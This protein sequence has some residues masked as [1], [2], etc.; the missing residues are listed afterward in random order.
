MDR[1]II[2][3]PQKALKINLDKSIY[4]TFS[5]IGAGQEVVRHFFRAGAASGTVAKAMSAYDKEFSDAI[6][7]REEDGRYVTEVRLR[8]MLSQEYRLMTERIS[9][10]A[11]PNACFFSFANTVATIDF[12][13]RYKGHGWMG[14][15]FQLAPDRD[16]NEVIIHVRMKENEASLQQETLGIMGVN[17]IHACYYIHNDANEMLRALYDNLSLDKVE[18]DMVHMSGP[19][20][21]DVDNR[22]LS[23]QLVKNGFTNAV[24][25]GP[26]GNNLL[27]AGLLYKKHILTIRGSFRPVTRVNMD[28]IQTGYKYFLEDP[29]VDEENVEVL[30]EIT[31]NNLKAEGEIDEQDFV[32]RAEILCALG[33]KV[34]ISNF[35]QYYKLVHYFGEFTQARMGLIMGLTNLSDIFNEKYY[36]S[37][38]GGILEAM[39]VMFSR[40]LKVYV[41][42][43]RNEDSGEIDSI[44]SL[45]VHP[46]LRPL[47]DYLVFNGR[48]KDIKTFN[49]E[50]LDIFSRE[51]LQ[52]IKDNESGWEKCLPQ[53]VDTIIKEKQ[54]FGYK[55]AE[56]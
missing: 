53:Y 30:F 14:C 11:R 44:Q 40:D 48:I 25:F 4:G 36:R 19:D 41:Y 22:L 8:K 2:T 49:P 32:D 18:I 52:R 46:R 34:L 56:R 23:L 42:P 24:I 50:I 17:L 35:P 55:S 28:M 9:R 29:R 47:F 51:V 12:S 31:L 39:G 45:K 13:K 26:E 16:P 38:P 5:E 10:E 6:Y 21:I 27:P 15:K 3:T 37:L 54:L 7:G 43:A 20:F 1:Y 33:Q